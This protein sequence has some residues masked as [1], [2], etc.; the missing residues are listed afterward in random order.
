M[1]VS[2]QQR[3]TTEYAEYDIGYNEQLNG[4]VEFDSDTVDFCFWAPFSVYPLRCFVRLSDYDTQAY[5]TNG[6]ADIMIEGDNNDKNYLSFSGFGFADEW[7]TQ[8]VN[9]C[10]YEIWFDGEARARVTIYV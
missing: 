6:E 10:R 2:H 1:D 8:R 4:E 5:L 3:V 9:R 7:M